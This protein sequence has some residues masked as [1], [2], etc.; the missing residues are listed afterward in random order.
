[1]TPEASLRRLVQDTGPERHI[2]AGPSHGAQGSSRQGFAEL[3]FDPIEIVTRADPARPFVVAQL[4]QSLDG[5][6]ATPSGESRWINGE[7]ALDHLHR[8]RAAVDAVVVGVGTVAADDPRLDVRRCPGSNPARVVIDPSGRMPAGALVLREDGA[9]RIVVVSDDAEPTAAGSAE[10]LRIGRGPADGL[11]PRALV[12]ALF[13]R[14][15]RRILVEGG[16]HTI[17]RFLEADALDRL[18]VLVAPV[19]L[20]SGRPGLELK[21]IARLSDALRPPTT[22]HLMEGGDVLFDCDLRATGG[23]PA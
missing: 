2:P 10:I 15:L 23:G 21:P 12:D 4:G 18:H 11:C 9:R 20:G 7:A 8:L 13:A 16:A 14:G 6:I 3:C 22:A 19:I 1:M 5:R 17:S